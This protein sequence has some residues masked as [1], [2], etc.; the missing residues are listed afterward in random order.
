MIWRWLAA[1]NAFIPLRQQESNGFYD[2]KT[3]KDA[4]RDRRSL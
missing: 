2:N 3:G 1:S 4:Q